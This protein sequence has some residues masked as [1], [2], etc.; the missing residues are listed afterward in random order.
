MV[1][2]VRSIALSI[3]DNALFAAAAVPPADDACLGTPPITCLGMDQE[4][5][6]SPKTLPVAPHPAAGYQP[7]V[8]RLEG[9][10]AEL[11]VGDRRQ[12][13]EIVVT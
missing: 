6:S 9:T 7:I 2:A 1:A 5:R 8:G 4:T 10:G 12:M 3:T 13:N 11:H